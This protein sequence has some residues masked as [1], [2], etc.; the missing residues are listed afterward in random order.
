MNVMHIA[1]GGCLKAPPVHYGITEDT[2]GHIAYVLGAALA[3]ADE[4]NV[5]TVQIVTRWFDDDRLGS[6]YRRPFEA[7]TDR[8]SIV[9]LASGDK[10]YLEKA[11][12][13]AEL[14]LFIVALLAHIEAQTTKPDIIHAHFADAA[15]AAM[16]VR[17]RFDIP[18]FYT[19]HS[20]GIDKGENGGAVEALGNRIAQERAAIAAADGIIVSSRDEAERQI[21]AYG[22]HDAITRVHR[23]VPGVNALPEQID[24][25]GALALIAPF[26]RNPEKPMILAVARPVAKKN[27]GA[28]VDAFAARPALSKI[29]NLVVLAGL[30]QS[31]GC[32]TDEQQG[33][34]RDL[35]EAIDR[36]DLYGRVAVP[37]RHEPQDV[38]GLYRLAARGG[39]L[40][41]NPALHEPFGLTLIEAAK[42]GLP[43]V[44]TRNGGPGDILGMIGHG[45]LIDPRDP[46]A[47]ADACYSVLTDTCLRDRLVAAARANV[48]QFD[49]AAYARR[50]LKLYAAAARPTVTA[51]I[52]S[53]GRMVICDI[54]NTLTGCA[55]SALRFGDWAGQRDL[56]FIVATG[57]SLP[58]ARAV[59]DDWALPE[60]DAY[61]TSVGTE[62]FIRDDDGRLISW[63]AFADLMDA[64]WCP[65]TVARTIA[66]LAIS[67]QPPV[68]QRRHKL[69]YFGSRSDADAIAGVLAEEGVAARVVHSHGR[70]I[71]V[72]PAGAGKAM[73]IEALAARMG[74]GLS[75]CIAAGDSGNDI[76]MLGRCG[77]AI[78]VANAAEDLDV[79]VA[80]PGLFRSF[81]R[82]AD[83]VIEGLRHFGVAPAA[84]AAR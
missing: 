73:A 74:L 26:L 7:V 33:V 77:S 31:P 40:F 37:R 52:A 43:V 20:L 55:S 58:E 68:D 57:R 81:G 47:I 34:I 78:L 25:T 12:L 75:D 3:Q 82:H 2:G 35:L 16:A 39:G 59:M 46:L 21:V 1:L 14:P 9:R 63:E 19:P 71:D 5:A 38:A 65:H 62:V 36:H 64:D 18:F 13:T 28:L 23:V 22:V 30:R 27:L 32:G 70:L 42:A 49:W 44:A 83:G 84:G 66:G 29:A 56:P 41:A 15:T 76:D 67:M 54:D 17:A 6:D 48:G 11:G 45:L 8:V 72:L 24:T 61:I 10:R 50:S 53:T 60:P 80:R 69:S 79:L 4:P 51:P